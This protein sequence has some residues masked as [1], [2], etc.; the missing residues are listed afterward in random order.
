[1]IV[2]KFCIINGQHSVAANKSMVA[3]L[4]LPEK[5]LKHFRKWNCFIVW[6]KEKEKLRRI[7]GFYNRVNHFCVFKPDWSTNVLGARFIWTQLGRPT[8]RPI[9]VATAQGLQKPKRNPPV[10]KKYQVC[11]FFLF[12]NIR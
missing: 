1:M 11:I 5:T 10:S 4:D 9:T 12:L 2:K 6:T 7:S 3:E 8:P